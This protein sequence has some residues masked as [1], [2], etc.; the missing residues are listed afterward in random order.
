MTTTNRIDEKMLASHAISH[1]DRAAEILWP[2]QQFENHTCGLHALSAIYRGFGLNPE[3]ENLRI[4][5]G[6]DIP[7]VPIDSTTTGT[8]HP[9]LL[10]VLAE[11][12]L[13]WRMIDPSLANATGE[14]AQSLAARH[15]LLILIS[16]PENGHLHWIAAD[17]FDGQNLRV[18]D[19]LKASP[20]F[21]ELDVFL[22]DQALSVIEIMPAPNDFKPN[23]HLEG[24]LE[25]N[26]VR[27][28]LAA[29]MQTTP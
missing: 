27:Q 19:S 10:R 20:T 17:R 4:R 24:I 9:D 18:I 16:R 25:M 23:A 14:I 5:L 8:L 1:P 28:R 3:S 6:V 21:F 29:R 26:A 7:A 11:D 22:R 12:E 15:P 2:E 13:A